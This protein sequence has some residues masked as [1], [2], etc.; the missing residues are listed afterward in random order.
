MSLASRVASFLRNL[1]FSARVERELDDELRG[2]VEMAVDE[3]RSQG[4]ADDA[5][6]RAVLL[7]VGGVDQVKESVRDVHA[8]VL[9]DQLRQDLSYAI[10]MLRKNAGFTAAAVTTL[11]LGIGANTA[12][13]SVVDAVVFRPLPYQDPDRLVKICGKDLPRN[14]RL[15]A[16]DGN[17]SDDVSLPDFLDIRDQN[18]VFEQVAADDGEGVAV[19][20]P[21]GSRE[22]GVLSAF[23][24]VG[25]LP[26]LGVQPMLGR[27]FLED[28]ERRGHG[29]VVILTHAFWKRRFGSDPHVV[30]QTLTIGSDPFTVVGVLPPNVLRYDADLL[31]PLVPVDYPQGRGYRDLDVF[32]RLKRGVTLEQAQ[33]E[34]DTIA[35]RLEQEYPATNAN[36][37]YSLA[38]LGRYYAP[39]PRKAHQGLLLMLGA[40]GMVLL[41]ACANVANLL[42]ARSVARYREC[43]IRAALGAGRARLIRQMLIESVL[44]FLMG[45]VFGILLARWSIDS[46]RALAV[47]GE[48]APERL[49]IAVDG[50]VFV[51]GLIASLIA[52]VAAGLVPA[53]QASKVDPSDGLKSSTLASIG[54]V[55]RHRANR[56]L[57]ISELA[58]SIVLLV[59][60]GL[61]VRSFLRVQAASG[62]FNAE[63]LLVTDSEG[64]RSFASAVAFWHTAVERARAMPG[65]EFAAVTS[66]P[67]VHYVRRQPFAIAGHPPI[68]A[69]E[70]ARAGDILIGPDYFRTMGIPLLKGRAFTENDDGAAPPVVIVSQSL[71]RRHFP[72]EDPIGRLL[73]VKEQAPMLCCTSA[74][75]TADDVWRVI[76]G[77]AGDV[78]QANL[79]EPPA[80]TLYRPYSQMVEHDM[81]LLVRTRSSSDATR[82]E[83]NLRSALVAADPSR[84]WSDVRPMHQVIDRSESIRLRR[85]VLTLLG[86]F[87]A[88][89]LVLA[90]VGTYGVMA[91]A[92]ADRTREIGIR[93]ALGASRSVILRQVLG[94]TTKLAM[95]GLVL[96]GLAAQAMTRFI[97]A[98]LFDVSSADV[99]TYAGVSVLLTSVALL[100]SYIPARRAAQID[101]MVAL[102]HE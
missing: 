75:S 13:F 50:R 8:G 98:M 20:Y 58:L 48:Y 18:H 73:K 100:A 90:A 27:G 32:A 101:P 41:I 6:R 91:Y 55:R 39:I 97:S 85:F 93:V 74:R 35:R 81:Y 1:F 46:L 64:G 83:A 42:L 65:V 43:A 38:R 5:A 87:A 40:V 102:R 60:F 31:R 84:E 53:L 2:Y 54:N 71:A 59:G 25:W 76:V 61:L 14:M 15:S 68:S 67:P 44:L 30:G 34:V 26:T 79:D 9:V 12:I 49:V 37:S 19:T 92:V 56:L 82:V 47:A 11:A 86:S 17:C 77:V 72:N 29:R 62:G 95:A 89:A 52:G 21:D 23:V 33:A 16:L 88:L 3:K 28:E 94:E 24:T 99:V 57:I 10:R 69:D 7:E 45:G 96:G 51:V 70:D 22:R 66:R 4:L 63:H 36:R 80:V 78:R